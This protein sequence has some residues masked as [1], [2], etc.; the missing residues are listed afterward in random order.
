MLLLVRFS[1]GRNFN[2]KLLLCVSLE[3]EQVRKRGLPPHFRKRGQA[4]L[5]DLFFFKMLKNA[6][7]GVAVPRLA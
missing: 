6:R 7:S 2:I 1:C 5:P 3:K 4:T